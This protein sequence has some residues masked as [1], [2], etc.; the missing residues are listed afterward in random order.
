MTRVSIQKIV[1]IL[2]GRSVAQTAVAS[3]SR[4]EANL[5][6][7]ELTSG[8]CLNTYADLLQINLL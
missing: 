8:N 6:Q 2:V 5:H 1:T 4:Q 7:R 3:L